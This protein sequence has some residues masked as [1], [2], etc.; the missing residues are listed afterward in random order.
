[1]KKTLLLALALIAVDPVGL[2]SRTRLIG[3]RIDELLCRT[4]PLP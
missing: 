2:G 1:M 4:V 3:I